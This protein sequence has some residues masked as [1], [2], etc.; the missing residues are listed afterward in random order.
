M[1][2]L[3]L[4]CSLTGV[5]KLCHVDLCKNLREIIR[6]HSVV[7]MNICKFHSTVVD[8]VSSSVNYKISFCPKFTHTTH[9]YISYCCEKKDGIFL[10]L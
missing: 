3:K 9:Y 5:P 7:T 2:Y 4:L 10:L 1:N 6:I 8:H